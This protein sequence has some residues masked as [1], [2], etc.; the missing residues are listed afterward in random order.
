MSLFTEVIPNTLLNTETTSSSL[1]QPQFVSICIFIRWHVSD[2]KPYLPWPLA[3]MD[4]RRWPSGSVRTEHNRATMTS[5]TSV[6]SF[7]GLCSSVYKRGIDR[8]RS[9]R[10][11]H[12]AEDIHSSTEEP[13]QSCLT[14]CSP[15][16]SWDS[17][18]SPPPATSRT[19]PEEARERCRTPAWDRWANTCDF[20]FF[21]RNSLL[22]LLYL[23][24]GSF[25]CVP[26]TWVQF[27]RKM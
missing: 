8:Q 11:Q 18:P 27:V 5:D 1:R 7:V 9:V 12:Q 17:S 2:A 3:H 21:L 13:Q 4:A 22:A 16:A 6:S 14:P 19:A 23:L 25:K 10:H 15:C 20:F 24:Q 26:N